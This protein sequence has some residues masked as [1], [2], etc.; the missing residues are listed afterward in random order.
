M[1]AVLGPLVTAWFD[2]ERKV[3]IVDSDGV[4][5]CIHYDKAEVTK[6]TGES[7]GL[8]KAAIPTE[9]VL[10]GW[11]EYRR[12]RFFT[13]GTEEP[14]TVLVAYRDSHGNDVHILVALPLVQPWRASNDTYDRTNLV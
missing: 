6:S 2:T 10:V 1:A 5:A 12:E 8:A 3:L 7:P 9:R 4:Q 13:D 14:A 11:C